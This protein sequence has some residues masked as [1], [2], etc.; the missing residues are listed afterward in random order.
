ML[1]VKQYQIYVGI[2]PFW[3]NKPDKQVNLQLK[4]KTPQISAQESV[5]CA[6]YEIVVANNSKFLINKYGYLILF[7]HQLTITY[8]NFKSIFS[9]ISYYR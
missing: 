1:N 5:L 7:F 4:F 9:T 6:R 8:I 3:N 2:K